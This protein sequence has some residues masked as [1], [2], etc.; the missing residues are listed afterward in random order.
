MSGGVEEG[1]AVSDDV[2][3]V[4]PEIWQRVAEQELAAATHSRN[5]L[6]E[7]HQDSY[8]WLLA[9][10]LGI[11][12]GG[13]F[14]LLNFEGLDSKSKGVVAI[15]FYL[16]II[17]ALLSGYLSQRANRSLIGPLGESMGYWISVAHHG[18]HIPDVWDKIQAKIQATIKQA[19]ATQIAGWASAI[20]FSIGVIGLGVNLQS[21]PIKAVQASYKTPQ[22]PPKPTK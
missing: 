15:F 4:D 14:A 1:G 3:G 19:R 2:G 13:M 8:K 7:A 10:L 12:S 9:S 6:L 21:L 20:C 11:N 16:G 22:L 17:A 18:E 5:V